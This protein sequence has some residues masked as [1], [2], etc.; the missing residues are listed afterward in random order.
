MTLLKKSREQGILV[1]CVV[2]SLFVAPTNVQ[3]SD[4]E[5]EFHVFNEELYSFQFVLS[6]PPS[7]S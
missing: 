1:E 7:K 2:V 6:L 3:E 4:S 5:L